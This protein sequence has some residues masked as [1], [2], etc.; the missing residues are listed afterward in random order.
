MFQIG[1]IVYCKTDTYEFGVIESTTKKGQL[2]VRLLKPTYSRPCRYSWNEY[3]QIMKGEKIIRF[4]SIDGCYINKNKIK[5]QY[6][7]FVPN[8]DRPTCP[9]LTVSSI[10]Q[11]Y[12]YPI[13]S[14][15]MCML[16][17]GLI[18]IK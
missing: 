4:I 6:H 3:R 18:L 5:I 7:K 10:V 1:D 13:L 14:V 16:G 2:R 15:S 8:S 11:K 12:Y 9:F 17:L